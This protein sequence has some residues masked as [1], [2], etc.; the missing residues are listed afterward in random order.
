M[1]APSEATS[2]AEILRIMAK[3]RSWLFVG[4]GLP[5]GAT[6]GRA[7]GDRKARVNRW[8]RFRVNGGVTP[9]G[10]A[11]LTRLH[12]T[13]AAAE[14]RPLPPCGG[15]LGRGVAAQRAESVDPHPR[16]LPAAS[17]ACPTCAI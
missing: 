11:G 15:G 2:A 5:P 7:I 3:T 1:A 8:L 13:N 16:P 10:E 6:L 12:S 4:N 17:R 9:S 14:V